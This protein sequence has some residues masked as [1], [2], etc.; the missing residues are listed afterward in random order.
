MGGYAGGGDI[1]A[2]KNKYKLTAEQ[3]KQLTK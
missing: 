1:A 2:I 3:E